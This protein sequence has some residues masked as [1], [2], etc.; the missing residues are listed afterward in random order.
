MCYY[1]VNK[2]DLQPAFRSP[3]SPGKQLKAFSPL[4]GRHQAM[5]LQ[6]FSANSVESVL[7]ALIGH[8]YHKNGINLSSR[9]FFI[10]N[11]DS[12]PSKLSYFTMLSIATS[13][14]PK[15]KANLISDM[16]TPNSCVFYTSKCPLFLL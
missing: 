2:I 12:P 13:F 7:L 8:T 3:L 6:S 4:P 9:I 15:E 11:I 16:R 14:N 5:L 10:R 1:M